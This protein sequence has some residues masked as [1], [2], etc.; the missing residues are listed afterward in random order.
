MNA[1]ALHMLYLQPPDGKLWD[2]KQPD[3]DIE[4]EKNDSKTSPQTGFLK[5]F[6]Q[7]LCIMSHKTEAQNIDMSK[8]SAINGLRSFDSEDVEI[9][10]QLQHE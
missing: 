1:I 5:R 10:A 6:A 3:K 8:R 9:F 7:A 2:I 4:P